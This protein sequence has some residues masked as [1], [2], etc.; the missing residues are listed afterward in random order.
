M[1]CEISFQFPVVKLL[2]YQQNWQQLEHNRNPFAT[3]VMAHLKAQQTRKVQQ[4]RKTWKLSL[5][6]R[7][8]EQGYQQEQ[9][10]DLFRFIDWVMALPKELEKEFRQEIN[11]YEEERRMRY[12]TSIERMGIEEGRKLGYRVLLLQPEFP[13]SL[14][15]C[16]QSP[17][18]LQPL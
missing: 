4:E 2:D 3:V 17:M 12:V 16:G 18:R 9:I 6:R 5:S 1:G 11:Q 14:S 15:P 10:I 13:V 8:Y 7:L